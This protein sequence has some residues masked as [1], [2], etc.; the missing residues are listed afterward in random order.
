MND[1]ARA[2][3]RPSEATGWEAHLSLGYGR[4]GSRTVLERR[5]H[6]G[7]LLVQK[8]LYPEGEEVCQNIVVHPPAGIVGGDRLDLEVVVGEGARAQLSTPGA[9]KWYRSAGAVARQSLRFTGAAG[10]LIEWLPQETIVFDGAIAQLD[11]RVALAGDA[12]FFGWE[13]VC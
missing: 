12:V 6:R 10:A 1:V 2:A 13:V 5:V 7:P 11:T 3:L 4:R 9:A 8:S